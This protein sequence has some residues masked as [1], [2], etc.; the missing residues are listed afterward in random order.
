MTTQE[1]IDFLTVNASNET[2]TSE[3][4]NALTT[5]LRSKLELLSV[6][7]AGT[8]PDAVTILYSGSMGANSTD[9]H[10]DAVTE[11]IRQTDPA[12]FRTIDKTEL[13]DLLAS[14][15]FTDALES[16]LGPESEIQKQRIDAL[17][18]GSRDVNGIQQADSLWDDASRRFTAAAK[19]DIVTITPNAS[20]DRV[21]GRTELAAALNSEAPTINGIPREDLIRLRSD[22]LATGTTPT[23]ADIET[24]D[25]ILLDY[26]KY[27]S[28]EQVAGLE[29]SLAND[30]KTIVA[31]GTKE[32]FN[33]IG[34]PG[35]GVDLPAG[36]TS[37]S[38]TSLMTVIAA[39]PDLQG[40][41]VLYSL[42]QA[43][44]R[45]ISDTLKNLVKQFAAADGYDDFCKTTTTF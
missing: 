18:N 4:F 27:N 31:V 42:H 5:E 38:A 11:A 34:L 29:F 32:Y 12:Y 23:L 1:I 36:N 28:A 7:V 2:L 33:R 21:F 26:V 43:M 20:V 35:A 15:P 39:L 44:L 3:Q 14:R 9:I 37:V 13:G 40:A 10:T 22:L 45:D 19:G 17:I 24:A 16:A 6:D 30:G 25:R 41:G 8:A